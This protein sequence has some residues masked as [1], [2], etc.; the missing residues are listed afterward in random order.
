MF[1]VVPNV[2]GERGAGP[3]GVVDVA[4]PPRVDMG[5][6]TLAKHQRQDH[7]GERPEAGWV[8]HGRAMHGRAVRG[9]VMH[10]VS[11]DESCKG[12]D[13]SPGTSARPFSMAISLADGENAIDLQ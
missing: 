13:A 10:G 8:T 12:G 9:L 7:V 6:D 2:E 5:A 3:E 1:G 11:V 4:A